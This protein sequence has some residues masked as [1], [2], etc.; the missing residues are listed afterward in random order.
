MS[1]RVLLWCCYVRNAAGKQLATTVNCKESS[2]GLFD[3]VVGLAREMLGEFFD[4]ATLKESGRLQQEKGSAKLDAL[5]AEVKAEVGNA[6]VEAL[7]KA[8]Q[9]AAASS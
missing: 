9:K 2:S 6:K 4:R 1:T 5:Q 8:Q 3:K 7:D